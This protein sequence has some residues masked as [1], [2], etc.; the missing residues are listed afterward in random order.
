MTVPP[1]TIGIE[2]EYLLLDPTTGVP[3]AA[4]AEVRRI[5]RGNEVVD[6]EV[7]EP[8]LL[9]VQVEVA[10]APSLYL[11]NAGDELSSLR[12]VLHAAAEQVGCA[13]AAVGAAPRFADELPPT[14]DKD[15]Y[16]AMHDH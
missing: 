7:V 4:S 3:V 8:E 5:A 6:A 14:S 13:I 15:R 10:I 11:T 16:Q 12:R 1:L 9:E 2:E